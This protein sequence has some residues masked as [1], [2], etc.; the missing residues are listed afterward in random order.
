M[1][2]RPR[3]IRPPRF[4]RAVA[5]ALAVLAAA[6]LAEPAAHG[7]GVA[8]P[9]AG[10]LR[11][12]S[13]WSTRSIESVIGC[14]EPKGKVLFTLFG[15][16]LSGKARMMGPEQA[17]ESLKAYFKKITTVALKDVTPKKSPKNVRLYEYTYKATGENA[18]T[19]HL[20]VKLK[21]D[22]KRLWVLASVTESTRPR[23]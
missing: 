1:P 13:A 3:R 18:R 16:P 12:Q 5:C 21:Q 7:A 4:P 6:L 9:E 19:T 17:K 15:Y 22:P 11:F 14:M 23:K 8:K 2:V 10:F 20:Q